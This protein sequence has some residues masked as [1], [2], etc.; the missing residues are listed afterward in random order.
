M[1]GE[2]L[3][4]VEKAFESNWITPLGPMVDGF[5]KDISQYVGLPGA[6]ALASG[7]AAIH[8]A[9]RL[10]GVGPGDVVFCPTL[11]FI[12]SANPVG[13][14][15]A[16]PVFLDS[17]PESWNLSPLALERALE[18]AKRAGK[19]PKA[20]MLVNLYG[21]T[22]DIDELLAICDHY[23]VPVLEDA[24]ESIGAE[25]R[26][27]PTGRFGRYG[28][29]SFN[30]NKIITTAGGGM[31]VSDDMGGIAKARF[32]ATQARDPA[33]HYEHSEVG[34]NYRM[35]NI[36]A[37][38]GRAQLRVLP[39]RVRARRFIFE[40]YVHELSRAEFVDFI[41]EPAYVQSTRWLTAIT[42]DPATSPVTPC[43][44]LEALESEN[45]EARPIWKPM[46][47]QPLFKGVPYFEH[48]P[49]EDVSRRLFETGVCLPSGS[50][51]SEADQDRVIKAIW[52]VFHG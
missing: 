15:G 11:T 1:S 19:L 33:P 2:E 16:T 41:P 42:L 18:T 37:A 8:L 39:E 24:A 10:M 31:L 23:G 7:T 48:R 21:Q 34:Y 6:L 36:L 5:E 44:L 46:H 4:E 25:Y 3:G 29:F 26:G 22:G 45:I 49:G 14:L 30:G 35:S 43:R 32:W 27:K 12:G 50:A 17:E 51:L 47:L 38:I 40:R 52:R 13:Y 20:V 28:V 9:L